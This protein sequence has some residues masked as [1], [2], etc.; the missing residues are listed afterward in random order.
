MSHYDESPKQMF[1]VN[2]KANGTAPM[3]TIRNGVTSRKVVRENHMNITKYFPITRHSYETFP[4]SSVE[5][6][7]PSDA[8]LQAAV[9]RQQKLIRNS[10]LKPQEEQ[11]IKNITDQSVPSVKGNFKKRRTLLNTQQIVPPLLQISEYP[12]EESTLYSSATKKMKRSTKMEDGTAGE[13]NF[14]F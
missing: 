12:N 9:L 1:E 10:P 11:T 13:S 4:S 14:R 3:M 6:P 7:N 2:N 5:T 8:H